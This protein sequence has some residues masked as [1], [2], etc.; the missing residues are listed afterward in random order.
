MTDV[1]GLVE[2]IEWEQNENYWRRKRDGK[3]ERQKEKE[4][5]RQR[6]LKNEKV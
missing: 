1:G 5:E 6:K 4:T 3:S 2:E